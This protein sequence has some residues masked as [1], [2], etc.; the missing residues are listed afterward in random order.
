[1]SASLA[2]FS[3]AGARRRIFQRAIH[4]AGNFVFAGAGLHADGNRDRAA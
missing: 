2:R 1:M 4:D 3:R